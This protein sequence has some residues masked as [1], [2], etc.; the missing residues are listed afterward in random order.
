MFR[1]EVSFLDDILRARRR[2]R[3]EV[4]ESTPPSPPPADKPST[5]LVFS[6]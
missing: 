5:L 1:E 4:L 2:G 3:P 6:F